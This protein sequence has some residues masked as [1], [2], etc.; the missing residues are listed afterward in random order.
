ML[1]YHEDEVDIFVAFRM[2]VIFFDT[3]KTWRIIKMALTILRPIYIQHYLHAIQHGRHQQRMRRLE[4]A[5]GSRISNL[6]RT[7]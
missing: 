7:R 3:E 6:K 5:D 1:K 2:L 4:I